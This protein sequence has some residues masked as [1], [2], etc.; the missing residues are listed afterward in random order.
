[1][2]RDDAAALCR[3]IADA[4]GIKHGARIGTHAFRRAFANRLG[5]VNLR[6]LKDLAGWKSSQTVVGTCLPTMS[7]Y[8]SGFRVP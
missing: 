7:Q 1:M 3:A 4:S 8:S 5:D 6:D 2:T